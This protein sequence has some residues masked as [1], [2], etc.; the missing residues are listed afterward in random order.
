MQGD[1]TDLA[2]AIRHGSLSAAE[3]MQASLDAAARQEPLGAIA[4]LDIAMGLASAHA[5]DRE[6][7]SEPERFA[8]RSFGGVPTLA[9]DLGGPFAGLPV[10]AG[11]RLFERKGG[12]ADSDLA[13]RFRDAGFC[14]FG[15]TTSPEFGLSLASEPAIGPL[16]RNPLDPARTAGGSS[17]GAAAAV[18]AGIVA[19]AHATDAGGSIRVPA[20]CCGLI[21][22][23]PTRGAIPGGPSF[24][25]HLAGIASELAVCRSVRDAA[26]IF[27]RL[28][29]S[30]RGPFADPSPVDLGNGRFRIGLLTETGAVYPTEDGRLAAIE[31]AARTLEGDGHDIVPLSWVEFESSVAASS[32]AFA[33]IVSVNLAALFT[34]AGEENR[35]EPLT[36]A[37][38]ARGRALPATSLWHTLNEAVMVSHR[39]WTLFDRVDCILMPMLSSAPVAIGSFPSDHVD[40]DLHL[41]RMTAFAPLACL[42]N[43]S[44]FPALTLPF[45]QDEHAMP[46][47]VQIMAPMGHEPGL[48]SI[49]ARLEAEG[50]WQHRF[51]VAG[52]PS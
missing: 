42:A 24:G 41:E 17:G 11:S 14:L 43:I 16:C 35:A 45:G 12:A 7:R 32:R 44:G 27:E 34:A 31:A 30:S 25:N 6:R 20:A 29:G 8:A 48:L 38:A 15:L 51:P 10:T 40:T 39:L 50:R 46:L 33:D 4:Y 1:A 47:P 21:G 13:A 9:K 2:A 5:C 37:F 23:K 19:I 18:A 26:L 22:M 28:R 49:A 3:A 36:R 52:L